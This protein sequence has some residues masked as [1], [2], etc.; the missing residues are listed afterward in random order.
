MVYGDIHGS[1]AAHR[2]AAYA[3]IGSSNHG[4]IL[5]INIL[6]KI[7]GYI[8]FDILLLIE[9]ITPFAALPR[10]SVSIRQNQDEFGYLA[11]RN[12]CI[13]RLVGFAARKPVTITARGPVQQ[14]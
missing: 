9:A 14:V 10:A 13:S 12:Q 4:T 3:S 11:K 6:N 2:I 5:R 8:C 1:K 7:K